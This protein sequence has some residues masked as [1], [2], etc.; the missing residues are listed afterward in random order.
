MHRGWRCLAVA[1]F[2][3]GWLSGG[4]FASEIVAHGDNAR[5]KP[6]LTPASRSLI[7]VTVSSSDGDLPLGST[8]ATL[9]V[10]L[11]MAPALSPR[12]VLV[13]G[14]ASA[15]AI[16]DPAD[17]SSLLTIPAVSSPRLA[18]VTV[19]TTPA[20]GKSATTP[21]P[22]GQQKSGRQEFSPQ[23]VG[24][25]EPSSLGILAVASLYALKRPQ[26]KIHLYQT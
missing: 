13:V 2:G 14:P 25:P 6:T 9:P 7:N 3:G 16:A 20:A 4:V 26:R 1:I 22:A 12:P 5:A 15:N 19:V 23:V 17:T 8:L 18:T 11:D 10:G 24:T 21:P